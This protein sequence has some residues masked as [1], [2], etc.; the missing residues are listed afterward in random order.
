MAYS[1]DD[2]CINQIQFKWTL[3]LK[4]NSVVVNYMINNFRYFNLLRLGSV[5]MSWDRSV[6]LA[7]WCDLLGKSGALGTAF[8]FWVL[9]RE[10][11]AD[12]VCIF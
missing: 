7:W 11:T 4:Y 5:C 12:E 6:L 8:K 10:N 2:I 1:S 3:A 9:V